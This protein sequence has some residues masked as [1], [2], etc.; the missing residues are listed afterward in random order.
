MDNRV[1]N[2]PIVVVISGVVVSTV[3]SLEV[4][5]AIVVVSS[6]TVVVSAVVVVAITGPKILFLWS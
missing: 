2:S 5:S 1:V 4:N 3:D 6:L